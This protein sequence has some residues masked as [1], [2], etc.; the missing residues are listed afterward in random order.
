[1]QNW[2]DGILEEFT[3]RR[4]Y[5]P[6]PY[7]PV[8]TGRVV[9]NDDVSERFLWD[10]RRTIADVLADA[11]YAL[12]AQLLHERGLK[13]YGEAAGTNSPMLQDA[14]QNNRQTPCS[15]SS[16]PTGPPPSQRATGRRWPPSTR[17]TPCA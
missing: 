16:P 15:T 17:R 11:H 13:L 5:D 2:S 14:L 4:G 8:L 10:F 9:D 3:T 7:L 12:P 6:R 1:M